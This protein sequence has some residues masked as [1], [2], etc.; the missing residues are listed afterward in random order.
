MVSTTLDPRQPRSLLGW[1]M[2]QMRA[3]CQWGVTRTAVAFGCSPSHVTRVELGQARPSRDLLDFYEQQFEGDGL[4]PSLM[5]IV[6]HHA[7]QRRRRAAQ[8]ATPV[9]RTAAGDASAFVD[10]QLALGTMFS[11]GETF[12]ETWRI[13]NVG[14]VPWTGRQL[15]RQGP[16]VGPGLIASSRRYPI[17]ETHPGQ[18]ATIVAQLSAPTYDCSTI[19][20]F[21]MVDSDG[22]LCFPDSYQVGLDVLILVRGQAD[23][24]AGRSPTA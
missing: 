22:H 21:K 9:P 18:I 6:E 17:P 12:S 16:R 19:A 11:P 5:E 4:L 24:S 13:Q 8:A 7:E 23:T 10:S 1:T 14:R 3:S 15:E 2:R 20:Y